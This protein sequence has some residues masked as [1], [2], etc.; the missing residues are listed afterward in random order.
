[1]STTIISLLVGCRYAYHNCQIL[2]FLTSTVT[3][4]S[5]S[6]DYTFP[7]WLLTSLTINTDE[8]LICLTSLNYEHI[9]VYFSFMMRYDHNCPVYQSVNSVL[10]LTLN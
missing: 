9:A 7:V 3:F 8:H 2:L 4:L 1:M 6:I 5:M 10:Q